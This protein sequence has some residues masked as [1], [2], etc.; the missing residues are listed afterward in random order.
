MLLF[1]LFSVV[2]IIGTDITKDVIFLLSSK[3]LIIFG[4]VV[5]A[6]SFL[7]NISVK[8]SISFFRYFSVHILEALERHLSNN[9]DFVVLEGRQEFSLICTFLISN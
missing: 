5:P 9:S 4:D 3:L 6:R 8:K 2:V 7:Y 1:A